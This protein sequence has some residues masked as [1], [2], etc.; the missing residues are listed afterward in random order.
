MPTF[1]V[2]FIVTFKEYNAKHILQLVVTDSL[3]RKF[4]VF[5]AS[6]KHPHPT[7]YIV[8]ILWLYV[9]RHLSVYPETDYGL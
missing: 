4:L 8:Y 6:A 2:A 7:L 3:M 5:K 9:C 1:I